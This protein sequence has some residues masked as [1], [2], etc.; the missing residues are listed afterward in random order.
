MI[1]FFKLYYKNISHL[2]HMYVKNCENTILKNK[3]TQ[4]PKKNDRY[5]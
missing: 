5:Y 1:L 2:K 4:I 3:Q